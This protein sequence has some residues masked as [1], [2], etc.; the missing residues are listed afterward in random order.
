MFPL[1]EL[2]LFCKTTNSEKTMHVP[3]SII[4]NRYQIIQK[5][6]KETN[7]TYLAKDL[8]ATGDARCAVEHLSHASQEANWKIIQQHWI[9][10][11]EVLKRLGDH[12]QIPQFY[13]YAVEERKFY[14]IREYIDGDNLEQEA[15]RKVLD[16]AA[17]I[18]LIQNVLRI[19]DFLHKTNVIHCDIQPINLVRRKS[20]RS[21]ALVN[22]NAIRQLDSTT[23]NLQEELVTRKFVGNWD[24]AAPEQQRGESYFA[25]DI[26]A[27]GKTAVYALTGKSTQELERAEV[28]WQ[29][30]YQITPKLEAIL[31]QMME[32]SL[33]KRYGS[34]LDVLQDLRPLLKIKQ[35]VGGRYAITGYLGGNKG[36]ESY[37]ADNLHRQYQSPCL[38]KQIE[39]P[40]IRHDS[41]TKIERRYAEELSILE[42]L[43]YHEQ[44]P[45]LWDHFAE[46][47]EFY[48][49]QEYIS[50]EN[51]A[52]KIFEQDLTVGEVVQILESALGVLS[53]IHQ[54]RIIHRNIKP[55][56]LLIPP[57]EQQVIITDFG[58]LQ[59]I[60]NLPPTTADTTLEQQNYCSPEQI[61]GRPTISSDIY[62]LG[63]SMVE[64]LTSTP[65]SKFTRDSQTG[66]LLWQAEGSEIDRRLIKIIDKM[67]H[68][69]LGQRYQSA[70][71]ILGDL[72]KIK[73][74]SLAKSSVK[75]QSN[76]KP[77]AS[78]RRRSGLEVPK[79]ALIVG[80]LGIVCVLGS[81][82][83]AFPTVR[84]LFYWYRGEK[85]LP[86]NP[87]SALSSFTQAIDI[88]PQ[89][90]LAWSGRGDALFDLKQYSKAVEAY[91]EAIELNPQEFSNWMKQGDSFY[92]LERLSEAIAV[93]DRALELEQGNA[94]LYNHRGQALYDMGDYQTALAMQDAALEIDRFKPQ[95]LSDRARALL[96][97]GENDDALASFNR[98]QAVALPMVELWQD[99]SLALKALGRPQ[100][101]ERVNREALNAYNQLLQKQPQNS[102][103]W[104]AQADFLAKIEMRTKA[105]K[106]YDRTLELNPNLAAAWLGKGKILAQLDKNQSAL[107]ALNLALTIR[108]ELYRAWQAKGQIY[109]YN[110]RD[111]DEA[112]AAYDRGIA[113]DSKYAPL[114][115]DRGL[116]LNQ[117]GRYTQGI[118]SLQKSQELAAQDRRTWLG[119]AAGWNAVGQKQKA[120]AALDSALEVAPR[121]PEIWQQKGLIY[122]KDGQY[123]E[124]CDT[125]RQARLVIPD[126]PMIMG[127]MRSLGCRI[128]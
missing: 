23:L 8:Q 7:Q 48:L 14:L 127:S 46:N 15:E 37:I 91:A 62:A 18:Y 122:T 25:T 58:I 121:D 107:T 39:I 70:E 119:L 116:A 31:S 103:I 102:D 79:F 49:V 89:S 72:Q 36:I 118:E 120:L 1:A 94:E 95:Y 40:D 83:F 12:P 6:G 112:I 74:H 100:E 81:I 41:N 44:I 50:S 52:Q 97:L 105:S 61:A 71:K 10:E 76:I 3:G 108:P 93:Y 110:L 34:A 19:L 53:F 96:A 98:V 66:R 51:L 22:F 92:Q 114:W 88:K 30:H 55:S 125:Y 24:Y 33:E 123:N 124:A 32:P 4:G 67:T 99:K 5:L 9:N 69:D 47:D 87:Q 43:G 82:E 111:L 20:D 109:Q 42:R 86:K 78:E 104:L 117:Q 84:P 38:V 106:T 115:R 77:K 64:A 60:Q 13:N 73:P 113:I 35:V 68:L 85:Q 11:I 75:Q 126:S 59:D 27:L 128:N 63:M 57:G 54:N 2:I 65:P 17:V 56:N 28:S 45:Q 16:E 101:A 29:S 80:L 21:F 90:S 26:Y